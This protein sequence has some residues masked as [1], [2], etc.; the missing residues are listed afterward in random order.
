MLHL[1]P[2]AKTRLSQLQELDQLKKDLNL[3]REHLKTEQGLAQK[4]K[5]K[6]SKLIEAIEL[7]K[8]KILEKVRKEAE[9]KIDDLIGAA[10]AEQTMK[11]HSQLQEVKTNLPL[12]IKSKVGVQTNT[13]A[14]VQT[15]EAFIQNFPAGSKVFV[16]TLGQ[17]GIVQSSPNSKG[18]V[19]VLSGSVRML[20][21]WQSL[22]PANSG[23][24]PTAQLVRRAHPLS[25]SVGAV[26]L[27]DTDRQIDLRGKTVEEAIHELELHLDESTIQNED[28]IKIIHGHGT[29]TLKKA[30]RT[31][32]SRNVYVK[33]WKAGTPEQ[34]GDGVTWAELGQD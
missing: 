32:L 6:H 18:E 5:I 22:K 21:P 16:P 24:N 19:F 11:K 33:K 27:K 34:G 4:E 9:R 13:P 23:I 29:E 8:E 20:L 15:L 2:Q 1:S 28:R 7:E 30:I 25:S 17:D 3:L 10:K 12:I 31:F 14:N 26:S